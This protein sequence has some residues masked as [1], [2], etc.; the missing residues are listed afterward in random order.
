MKR[1]TVKRIL[2]YVR[3]YRAAFAASC[4]SALLY[5]LFTLL[6]P[7]FTGRAIDNILGP[8]QVDLRGV[9]YYLAL[10]GI[11]VLLAAASQW[12][13]NVCT[14][15]ISSRASNDMRGEAFRVLNR[16]PLKY[17]DGHTHGDIISRM[18]NDADLVA[19]GLLQGLTQLLPG[20]ATILGTLVVMAVLNPVIALVV[21]LVTPVSIAF[22]GFVARRTT[23]FFKAQSAAQGRLSGFV[24]E[25]VAGQSVVK[26]FGYEDRCFAQFDAISDELYDTG[27]KSVFYSSVTN[28]GTRFVNAI[29]YAAVGVIG[30]ISAIGGS[31][32][33]GQLSC[34]LTYANQYTKPFNEVTGVLTQLQTA[35]ASAE[36]LFAVIDEPTE[37]PDTPDA[38]APTACGGRVTASH[39]DFAYVPAVPLIEDFNLDVMP[40]QRIAIVGP[41]GCGKTT[42][43]NL[44]MRFYEVDRGEIAVDGN[45]IA[46]LRRSAL[47]GMYGMVLQETWLKCAT[48]RENIAYGK[49][50]ATDEEIIA[51]ARTARVDFFVRTM[52]KGYDTVLGGEAENLSVGQRQLLTIAR[53]VLRDPPVLILD[54]ATSSIDT[55]TEKLVQ[56][57]MDAL[58]TGRTTFVI[59]HRLSTV[60]NADC[61][62]VMEQ[63]RIMERGTHEELMEKKGMYYRLYTG[64]F[65][66]NA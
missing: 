51:A 23:G 14:R 26:A 58:M 44:L 17:I 61:I 27:L 5:V 65:A 20:V 60:R 29:V 54:E 43:I 11:S 19:E 8:G 50:D 55:R 41:T 49:P 62:M 37:R 24:N 4:A 15:K 3:P 48:V 46:K 12:V 30:A 16:T 6:G 52:P 45:S 13:M 1:R 9:L 39:V 22:A 21:V 59:A 34:F 56:D 57:G 2:T 38:L 32:T 33:V 66:D 18:V 10:L 53:V 7:V 64:N 47:R 63:G 42:L 28:P 25:M 36:R 40:G 31:I 35:V